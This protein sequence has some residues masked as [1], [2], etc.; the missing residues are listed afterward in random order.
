MAE[1]H[2]FLRLAT[3]ISEAAPYICPAMIYFTAGPS[4]IYPTV[5]QHL[6]QAVAEGVLSI[7]HRGS[8]FM[9]IYAR[10]ESGLR[11]V[12]D[13]PSDYHVFVLSSATEIW[14]RMAM[15]C[16][17]KESFHLVN[18]SF[19]Q[20]FAEVAKRAGKQ[21]TVHQVTDFAGFDVETIE[22]PESAELIAAIANESSTGVMMPPEDLYKLRSR[23]P[24]KLIVVDAVSAVPTWRV[25]IKQLDGLYFSVQKGFGLPAGLGV[26]IL[27]P[28]MLE[29]GLELERKGQF[30]GTYH[31]WSRLHEY[32]LKHQTPATPNVLG[33][34]LLAQVCADMAPVMDQ[35]LKSHAEKT[36]SL[37]A[38]IE[39]HPN[40]DF[41]VPDPRVRSNTVIV[42]K[43]TYPETKQLLKSLS[44]KGYEIGSGYGKYADS[45]I[46]ISN[47]PATSIGDLEGLLRA[48]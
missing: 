36:R 4:Q 19:S 43:H 9:D 34:Y 21:A 16:V 27:S 12:L 14:E 20:Y 18:G 10:M 46:R 28:R 13:I 1:L 42:A 23:Y 48:M 22:V 2:S 26:L 8:K 47:F 25:D 39:E 3:K 32:S 17:E 45:Q 30:V 38:F 29:R 35:L 37:N 5:P 7:S 33:I 15:N 11:S 44:A 40:Y 31:R 41:A 6:Q 24:E